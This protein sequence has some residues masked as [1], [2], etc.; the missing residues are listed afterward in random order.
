MPDPTVIVA[1]VGAG[2]SLLTAAGH[3]WDKRRARSQEALEARAE[4]SADV[5]VARL[6]HDA[7]IRAQLHEWLEEERHEHRSCLAEVAKVRS[8]F[9]TFKAR[10]PDCRERMAEMSQRIRTLEASVPPPPAP[11]E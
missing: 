7:T 10:H 8:E 11:A 6:G 4:D 5:Q 9:L 2:V 1:S 3:L